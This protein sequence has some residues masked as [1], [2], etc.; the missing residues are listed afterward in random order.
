MYS[1]LWTWWALDSRWRSGWGLIHPTWIAQS[2]Q[3]RQSAKQW[4]SPE[5]GVFSP[6]TKSTN[7]EVRRATSLWVQ[8]PLQ[9]KQGLWQEPP[10]HQSSVTWRYDLPLTFPELSLI[11]VND[12]TFWI[13]CRFFES[14][15]ASERKGRSLS[16]CTTTTSHKCT[17]KQLTKIARSCSASCRKPFKRE[18]WWMRK[19]TS[20]HLCATCKGLWVVQSFSELQNQKQMR[21]SW[22]LI[23]HP[24]SL[25]SSSFAS[26]MR[27]MPCSTRSYTRLV[28]RHNE[29]W[30]FHLRWVWYMLAFLEGA[31]SCTHT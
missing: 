26:L 11:T 20:T 8:S 14:L 12:R 13:L 22:S 25:H 15:D 30:R 31:L 16:L 19:H 27:N 1:P 18:K 29:A 9:T 4:S 23:S 21:V 3:H 24:R 7:I 6:L 17:S 10:P 28:R 5:S 2:N